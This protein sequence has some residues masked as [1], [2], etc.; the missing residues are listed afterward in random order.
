MLHADEE[1]LPLCVAAF[2]GAVLT[3]VLMLA[4]GFALYC[5]FH[6]LVRSHTLSFFIFFIFIY[7]YFI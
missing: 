4:V 5:C 1:M 6:D 7:F 3:L 2:A